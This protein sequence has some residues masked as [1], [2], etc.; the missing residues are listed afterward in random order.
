MFITTSL[1]IAV[2]GGIWNRIRGDGIPYGKTANDLAFG[3]LVGIAAGSYVVAAL[4][5]LAM[6]IGRA[7]GWGVYIGA[8]GGW[9]RHELKEFE[10]IDVIIAAWKPDVIA[11]TDEGFV[12]NPIWRLRMWGFLGLMLRGMI[13]GACIGIAIGNA[14]PVIGGALMPICYLTA[15]TIHKDRNDKAW[16]TGE[17]LFGAILWTFSFSALGVQ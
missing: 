10:P 12:Y 13:W 8:L 1:A 5:V 15:M 17:Y 11:K 2:C 14:W 3:L 4:G 7:F 9:E 16:E 6:A